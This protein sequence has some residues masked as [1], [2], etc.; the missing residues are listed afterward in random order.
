MYTHIVFTVE[1][2]ASKFQTLSFSSAIPLK[3]TADG[4]QETVSWF[5]VPWHPTALSPA[6]STYG[7]WIMGKK[8]FTGITYWNAV[9]PYSLGCRWTVLHSDEA[10]RRLSL[11]SRTRILPFGTGISRMRQLDAL[12]G[13]SQNNFYPILSPKLAPKPWLFHVVSILKW[14][15]LDDLGYPLFY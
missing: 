4:D 3:E 15:D 11:P 5:L 1:N 9:S 14:F 6:E 7:E 12:I 2:M 13:G 10:I 8:I